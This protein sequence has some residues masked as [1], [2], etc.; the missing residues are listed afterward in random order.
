MLTSLILVSLTATTL[1][2]IAAAAEEALRLSRTASARGVQDAAPGAA[3]TSEG[4]APRAENPLP[5]PAVNDALQAALRQFPQ[6][7]RVPRNA[8]PAGQDHIPDQAA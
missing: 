8:R 4:T 3:R 1:L 5:V 7:P 2:L 6:R